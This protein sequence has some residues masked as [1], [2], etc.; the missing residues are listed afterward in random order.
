MYTVFTKDRSA[1]DLCERV[2]AFFKTHPEWNQLDHSTDRFVR[3]D[4]EHSY[5]SSE[6]VQCLSSFGYRLEPTPP[7]DKHAN[8][9]AERTVGLA[10]SKCN[11][12][13]MAPTPPVPQRYW[14]LAF[15]YAC[16]TQAFNYHSKIGT[17]PYHLITQ[18]HVNLKYCHSFW[19]KCYVHIAQKDR[20]TVLTQYRTYVRT[21]KYT[22][23]I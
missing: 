22:S 11:L 8:G 21:F 12:V 1:P 3:A 16:I 2:T 14:D 19:S 13:M 15:N 10:Q 6:F 17:S 9:V 18:S 20:K 5:R 7:R 4:P 23:Y